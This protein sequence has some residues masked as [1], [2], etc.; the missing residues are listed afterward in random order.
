M[1]IFDNPGL[2]PS[3]CPGRGAPCP[4]AATRPDGD[5][6]ERVVNEEEV[7][8]V[9]LFEPQRDISSG[10]DGPAADR[11]SP[12]RG[13]VT[14]L[15][16]RAL[17]SYRA[18][19]LDGSVP[20]AWRARAARA[21]RML[22]GVLG[23]DPAQVVAVPDPDRVYGLLALQEVRLSVTESHPA[24]AGPVCEGYEFLPEFG[25][26]EAFVM[27]WPCPG[28][29]NPVPMYRVA[30]LADLGRHLSGPGD[31]DVEQFASDPGH[32]PGC[33]RFRADPRLGAAYLPPPAI[34][35]SGGSVLGYARWAGHAGRGGHAGRAVTSCGCACASG[36]WCGGCGHAG[37]VRR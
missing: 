37:C 31:P 11:D 1:R 24:E 13:Q 36:G 28:C 23:V 32:A 35:P 20:Q 17:A 27:L 22:A 33:D 15:A 2:G 30:T 10:K 26:T 34:P 16:G 5:H 6:R 19:P 25:M 12:D 4:H 8:N 18:A 3:R 14:G 7:M 29:S 21:V 9:A